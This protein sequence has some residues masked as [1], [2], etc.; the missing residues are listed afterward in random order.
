M[1]IKLIYDEKKDKLILASKT[2]LIASKITASY[3][4]DLT[5]GGE[6]LVATTVTNHELYNWLQRTGYSIFNRFF[7]SGK[8]DRIITEAMKKNKILQF[9]W[10]IEKGLRGK[11]KSLEDGIASNDY[12]WKII[13]NNTP[14]SVIEQ[15]ATALCKEFRQESVLIHDLAKNT[16]KYWAA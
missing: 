1:E 7:A 3:V 16:Y 6:I 8:M 15:I 5:P 12:T 10:T 9:G 2:D 13:L 14:I 11:Y 4:F